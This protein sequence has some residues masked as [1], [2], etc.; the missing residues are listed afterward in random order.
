MDLY[1]Y[2]KEHRFVD[3]WVNGGRVPFFVASTYKREERSGVYTPD[4]NLIDSS[5]FDIKTLAGVAGFK[6]D[7]RNI[8]FENCNFN[9]RI[10]NGTVNRHYEDGLVIC[11]STRRSKFIARKL[12]KTACVKIGEIGKL[13]YLI[14]EATG[15]EGQQ[16]LCRYTTS[17]ERHHFLKSTYDSWQEE[18]RLFWPG[19]GNIEINI[20]PGL[21]EPVFYLPEK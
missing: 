13:K 12:H 4:E 18:Y 2:L 8:R 10:F 3:T 15:V 17:H 7:N 11:M 21:A 14:D 5:T 1:L 6:G 9:G 20:P 19:V 16:G